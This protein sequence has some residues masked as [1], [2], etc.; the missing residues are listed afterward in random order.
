MPVLLRAAHVDDVPPGTCREV[1][2]RA[3]KAL[4]CRTGDEFHAIGA[5]CPHMGLP[6]KAGDFDGSK[7]TCRYHGAAV[8][9]RTGRLVAD[10]NR[11]EWAQGSFFRRVAAFFGRFKKAK[12]SCGAYRVEVRGNYV[13]I[14]IDADAERAPASVQSNDREAATVSGC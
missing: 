10:P 14:G 2:V 12:D 4:L 6:L 8:D 11:P 7:V 5:K 3:T 9:V 13:W 1:K